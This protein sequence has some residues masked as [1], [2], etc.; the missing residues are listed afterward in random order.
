MTLI[1]RATFVAVAF[2]DFA[3]VAAA[4]GVI[5]Y[6]RPTY[7]LKPYSNP[8]PTCLYCSEEPKRETKSVGHR[9][10]IQ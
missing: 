3:V 4:A 5:D 9:Q 2:V 1:H 7:R 8:G 10:T 6:Y